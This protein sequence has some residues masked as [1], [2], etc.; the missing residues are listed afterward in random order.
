MNPLVFMILTSERDMKA[1][2]KKYRRQDD[3]VKISKPAP[4]LNKRLASGS[5]SAGVTN[6]LASVHN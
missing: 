3:E 6:N 5:F 2:Q 4:N 1:Q